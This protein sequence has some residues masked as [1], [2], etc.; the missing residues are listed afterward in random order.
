MHHANDIRAAFRRAQKDICSHQTKEEVVKREPKSY[1]QVATSV[2]HFAVQRLSGGLKPKKS[3]P[4]HIGI[5]LSD[6]ER[7]IV[8]QQAEKSRLTLSEYVRAS[9]LGHGYVSAI[10][11]MKQQLLLDA[12]RELS[13]QGNNL[14]QIAKRL[15]ADHLSPEQGEHVLALLARSLLAAHGSVRYALAEGR[16]QT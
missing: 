7:E 1:A 3:R 9:I 6:S 15:N 8:V 12:V 10:D 13:R 11:P 4:F 5:R 2:E 14:N 16:W